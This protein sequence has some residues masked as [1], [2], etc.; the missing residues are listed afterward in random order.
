MSA[1]LAPRRPAFVPEPQIVAVKSP[2]PKPKSQRPLSKA[3]REQLA[4]ELRLLPSSDD[5]T[6]Q[7][8]EDRINQ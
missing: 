8:L 6:F 4:A 2:K 1:L 5:T 3:E 7:S